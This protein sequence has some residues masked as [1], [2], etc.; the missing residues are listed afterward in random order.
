MTRAAML[1]TLTGPTSSFPEE[2]AL[3]HW[4]EDQVGRNPQ[5]IAIVG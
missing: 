1:P 5:A 4:F 2:K 3:H